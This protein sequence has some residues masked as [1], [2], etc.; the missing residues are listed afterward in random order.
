MGWRIPWRIFSNNAVFQYLIIGFA[1]C[2]VCPMQ[3][4]SPAELSAIRGDAVTLRCTFR[5]SEHV[6]SRLSVDWSY[7]PEASS[8]SESVLYYYNTLHLPEQAKF[9]GRVKW[10]GDPA[11]GDAS[12]QLLNASLTDN[13]TYICAVKNPPDVYGAPGQ[14]H[15]TVTP[16]ELA[17]RFSDVAVLMALVLLPSLI[18]VLVLLGRM[19]CPGRS[20][21][22]QRDKSK[23]STIEVTEG[24]EPVRK[25]P[26]AKEKVAS[27]CYVY[28]QDDYEEYYSH[29]AGFEAHT[30]DETQC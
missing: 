20:C 18:I 30:V 21:C 29:K 23:T 8:P 13:G 24:E 10:L 28:L 6:T 12:I 27:C 19:C 5:S 9:K 1:L 22:K 7:R 15:L 11:R 16:R 26:S 3:V 25:D 2:Q 17:L 4:S 14:I